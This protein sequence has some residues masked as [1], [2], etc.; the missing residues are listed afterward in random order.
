MQASG[1]RLDPGAGD[2]L[3]LI[4]I[5]GFSSL[6]GSHEAD[7]F[8]FSAIAGL[9]TFTAVKTLGRF[10]DTGEEGCTKG[11]STET[12]KA[13]AHGGLGAF[14]Y[15]EVLDASFSFDGVVGAFAMT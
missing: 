3:L 8:M 5:L 9:L 4:V 2:R 14:L 11:Q 1:L 13:M 6:L 15:L 12:I 7:T 10:L